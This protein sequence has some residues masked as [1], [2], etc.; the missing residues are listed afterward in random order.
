M[1]SEISDRV[2]VFLWS[3]SR[4]KCVLKIVWRKEKIGSSLSEWKGG[5]RGNKS[6]P[7][8][9]IWMASHPTLLEDSKFFN[10]ALEYFLDMQF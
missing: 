3:D 9:G 5:S 6:S 4:F 10:L 2:M 7:Y 1:R 8:P